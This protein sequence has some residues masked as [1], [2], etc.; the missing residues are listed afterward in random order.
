M[1]EIEAIFKK[2]EPLEKWEDFI[3]GNFERKAGLYTSVSIKEFRIEIENEKFYYPRRI[4]FENKYVKAKKIINQI[5][6]TTVNG[7]KVKVVERTTIIPFGFYK[8][9]NKYSG[10]IINIVKDIFINYNIQSC[11][12]SSELLQLGDNPLFNIDSNIDWPSYII[13]FKRTYKGKNK[14]NQIASYPNTSLSK[15][16]ENPILKDISSEYG[17]HYSFSNDLINTDFLILKIPYLKIIENKIKRD[18]EKK[19][20]LFFVLEYADSSIFYTTKL[21]IK[22]KVLI[23]DVDKEIVFDNYVSIPFDK[24]KYQ[25]FEVK[26]DC[27]CEISYSSIE[28]I[29]NNTLVDKRSGYYIRSFKIDVKTK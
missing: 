4:I 25:V 22:A 12:V 7:K 28:L 20:K 5:E 11:E 3:E 24:S 27:N 15:K 17:I 26:P 23:K 2:F 6:K 8:R 18:I 1:N 10:E 14:Q 13:A 19:E 29:I 16:E 21:D 9:E